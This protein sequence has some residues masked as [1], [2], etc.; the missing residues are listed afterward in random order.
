MPHRIRAL[1][2]AAPW[3]GAP[4]GPAFAASP[5][6]R[7]RLRLA[8]LRIGSGGPSV[9]RSRL[10]SLVGAALLCGGVLPPHPLH[11]R[12]GATQKPGA[13]PGFYRGARGADV[14]TGMTLFYLKGN[15]PAIPEAGGLLPWDGHV[16]EARV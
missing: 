15:H 10:P 3:P 1:H 4:V 9:V 2:G 13:G 16:D 14:G 7:S 12:Q 5:V 8:A 6:H 11:G